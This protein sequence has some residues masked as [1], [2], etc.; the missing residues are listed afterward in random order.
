LDLIPGPDRLDP[1]VL[2]KMATRVPVNAMCLLAGYGRLFS[3]E[4]DSL[5]GS[6]IS[7]AIL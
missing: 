7:T 3:E 2:K 6:G 4:L 1:G 5:Q